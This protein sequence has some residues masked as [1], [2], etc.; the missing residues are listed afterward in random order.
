[1]RRERGLGSQRKGRW[2]AKMILALLVSVLL[3]PITAHGVP[4][5]LVDRVR[6]DDDWLVV[7]AWD[8]FEQLRLTRRQ[9]LQ[10]L[11][12]YQRACE[13]YVDF[14]AALEPP[15]KR[16]IQTYPPYRDELQNGVGVEPT[17][18]TA[19]VK[20]HS[21]LKHVRS[22]FEKGMIGL[23]RH[24][25]REILTPA[26][27]RIAR[28]Y[29]PN[30]A[31]I[32]REA[33][34][35]GINPRFAGGGKGPTYERRLDPVSR[36]LESIQRE[37]ELVREF[38]RSTPGAIGRYLLAPAAAD[39]LY[40]GVGRAIPSAARQAQRMW[41]AGT[42]SYSAS[43]RQ[44]DIKRVAVLKNEIKHWNLLNGLHLTLGQIERLY[45]LGSLAQRYRQERQRRG[46]STASLERT[47]AQL[48]TRARQA[49]Y[50]GQRKVVDELSSC[51]KPQ[52]SLKNPVRVG[53]AD[54]ATKAEK[55]LEHVRT[56]EGSALAGMVETRALWEQKR[57]LGPLPDAQRARR[58]ELLMSVARRAAQMSDVDFALE[59]TELAQS[60]TAPSRTVEL[61]RLRN[62]IHRRIGKP[63]KTAS[64]MFNSPFVR[65]LAIRGRQLA[66]IDDRHD[67]HRLVDGPK[68]ENCDK[69]CALPH[70]GTE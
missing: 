21:G 46:R 15:L 18:D 66:A 59:K 64:L 70:R 39:P 42:R 43:D 57:W 11:P 62:D 31:R 37:L 25:V 10:L 50:P 33:G 61:T 38:Q 51:F 20:A 28:A 32:T 53:Q 13:S 48:E 40:R 27:A 44:R 7:Y 29:E 23:E 2:K 54:N 67:M 36:Q 4:P 3:W 52:P 8:F 24:V 69:G 60:I 68:A 12:V 6:S 35:A 58:F 55:W 26:Q 41:R 22:S 47:L 1:M 17:I 56:I 63:G 9:A 5:Q 34:Q 19:A 14:C 30:R 45:E 16:A 65:A 49:L